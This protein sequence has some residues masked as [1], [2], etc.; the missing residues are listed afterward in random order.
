MGEAHSQ[1]QCRLHILID[2]KQDIGVQK[3]CAFDGFKLT[4][5]HCREEL[6]NLLLNL[7]SLVNDSVIARI[8]DLLPRLDEC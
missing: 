6:L 5:S 2:L 1:V 4:W 7:V 8:V 3:H